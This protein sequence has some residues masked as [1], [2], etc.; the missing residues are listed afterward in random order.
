MKFNAAKRDFSIKILTAIIIIMCA[1]FAIASFYMPELIVA[2]VITLIIIIVCYLYAP[3]AFE[4]VD[5]TL[6]VY[7]NFGKTWY[8]N[9][10]DCRLIED[11][12]P[13]TV[14]LWGNGGVF[15]GTGIFWNKRY[16]VFRMY[17]TNARQKD[18]VV[19]ETENQIV[20][21]S[22]E[23]PQVFIESWRTIKQAT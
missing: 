22:P 4:I 8:K 2:A 12:V 19:V 7:R 9:I 15:A 20:I 17:V 3:V 10:T 23:N 6:I 13:F 18:F 1:G 5:G 16:G 14:R 11:R 21:I